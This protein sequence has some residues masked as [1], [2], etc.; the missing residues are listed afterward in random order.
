MLHTPVE[1]TFT[2]GTKHES[3]V[4]PYDLA[5]TLKKQI[6]HDLEWLHR[7]TEGFVPAREVMPELNDPVMRPAI[8][9]RGSRHREQLTQKELATQLGIRQ[10]HLSEMENGK[11]PI[12]KAMAKKL[13]EALNTNWRSFL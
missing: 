10:H 13:A 2:S 5:K 4:L 7:D 9:L 8:Y 12:G 11:R 3:F 1:I 6:K